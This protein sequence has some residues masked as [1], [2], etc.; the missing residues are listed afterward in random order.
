MP[1]KS[2]LVRLSNALG[3]ILLDVAGKR[4][5]YAIPIGQEIAYGVHVH[6]VQFVDR[7]DQQAAGS[8]PAGHQ[9]PKAEIYVHR[10]CVC[11]LVAF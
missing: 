9:I 4:A 6:R 11:V 7:S 10:V 8:R 5:I 1:K 2:H 3:K